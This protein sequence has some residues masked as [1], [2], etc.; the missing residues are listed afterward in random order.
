MGKKINIY[1]NDVDKA[2]YDSS[3][4]LYSECYDYDN[5]LK[6]VKVVFKNGATYL[7]K[8]VKV[9]DYLLFRENSSQ[10]KSVHK[11]LKQYETEKIENT[12]IQV[13]Q[14]GLQEVINRIEK[15]QIKTKKQTFIISAFPGC[16][17]TTAYVKLKNDFN[18]IDLESS[19]F[20]K[21]DFPNNYIEEI[22]NNIGKAYIIFISPHEKI[23][24]K[25]HEMNIPY[26]LFYPNI[27]RKDEMISLYE[28]RGNEKVFIELMKEHFEHFYES[29]VQ[30]NYAEPKI[31]LEYEGDFILNNNKIQQK[32]KKISNTNE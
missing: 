12:D 23:R 15:E 7:Y 30:D 10:G 28:E 21:N 9:N 25:L 29:V 14:E 27:A 11:I 32:I 1:E 6:T 17:K 8:N 3:T 31:C 2:W 16:G 22:Q 20:N 13:I 4:V 19:F 24:N 18:I 5:A 26:I